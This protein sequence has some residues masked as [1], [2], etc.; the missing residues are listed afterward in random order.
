MLKNKKKLI[1]LILLGAGG[2]ARSSI[3]VIKS[4]S[5][6]EILGFID[7]QIDHGEMVYDY[8]VLGRDE[9]TE[10]I[11]NTASNDNKQVY[12]LVTLG[13][14]RTPSVRRRLFQT[15][16]NLGKACPP[17]TSTNSYVSSKSL[18]S[19][20]TMVFHG[21]II[22][23]GVRVGENCIINTKALIEHDSIIGSSCH[24]STGAIINGGVKVGNGTFIGSGS[25]IKEGVNIGSNCIIGMGQKVLK[26]IE[27]GSVVTSKIKSK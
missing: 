11:F 16:L 19:T 27:S 23:T 4:N 3:D 24:I 6:Y 14:I 12:G 25:I 9:D 8:P 1:N 20:G 2:H 13:Q 7:N 15:L 22:N 10:K 21:A 26:D 18:I 17:I 5:N